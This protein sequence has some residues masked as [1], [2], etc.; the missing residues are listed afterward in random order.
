M[1]GSFTEHT[2][3]SQDLARRVGDVVFQQSQ[4]QKRIQYKGAVDLVTQFDT[5]AQDLIVKEIGHHYPHHGILS[6]ENISKNA[7]AP[8]KWI[9][10]PLDG[11]TNFA[12]GLP[13]WSIS[14]ALE[15]EG[16]IVSGAVYDPARRESFAAESGQGAL[17]NGSPINVSLID[18]L[19]KALLVTGFPYDIRDSDDNNLD[20]FAAFAVHSQ[21]VRRL[22]SAALDLCY[23]ACGRFDG[24]WEKK[25]SPWDQAAGMLILQE[26]GGRISDFQGK[27][28]SI[29]G[30]EVLATNGMIHE[31]MMSILQKA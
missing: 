13:I 19:D 11:T 23:V 20:N 5:H 31:Q 17:L 22:G 9:V 7:D 14:I 27:P 2:Q 29:Y 16:T 12:H 30:N 28:F 21:A 3:F 25:L 26:A 24:Y 8:M 1:A 18:D 6:E 4:Q 10:D 15:K